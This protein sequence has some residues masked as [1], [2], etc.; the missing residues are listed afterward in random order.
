[1]FLIIS[2]LKTSLAQAVV[3]EIVTVFRNNVYEQS[4]A[5]LQ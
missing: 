5:A 4:N 3:T 2:F 1:M